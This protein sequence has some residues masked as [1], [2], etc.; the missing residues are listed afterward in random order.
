VNA[1]LRQQRGTVFIEFLI[2]FVPFF[3]LFLGTTQLCLMY[4]AQL[5]VH[6]AAVQAVRAAVVTLD[7]DPCFHAGEDRGV[8]P[9]KAKKGGD[10]VIER[11]LAALKLDGGTGKSLGAAG[12]RGGSRLT[13]VRNA[14][15]LPLAAISPSPQQLAA[16]LPWAVDVLPSLGSDRSVRAALGDHPALRIASGFAAYNRVA[17]AITFPVEPGSKE[18]RNPAKEEVGVDDLVTVRVTYL[19]SCNVPVVREFMCESF[20][21]MTGWTKAKKRIDAM[22]EEPSI[23]NARAAGKALFE[24]MPKSFGVAKQLAR[25][26]GA[27]EWKWL[28]PAL[29]SSRNKFVA[30][31]GEATLPNQGADYKYPSELGKCECKGMPKSGDAS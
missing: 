27:A 4:A 22:R 5:V 25:E 11:G 10:G 3:L 16:M 24:D 20:L 2:S 19:F 31:R 18:L 29:A 1:L 9:M 28:V 13:K 30:L 21:D 15:Y 6:H 7:D 17:S 26:M 23:E 8:L 14:A 12:G